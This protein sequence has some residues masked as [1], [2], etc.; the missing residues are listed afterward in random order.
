MGVQGLRNKGSEDEG[1]DGLERGQHTHS[2]FTTPIQERRS[3]DPKIPTTCHMQI[4]HVDVHVVGALSWL[5][6]P[7]SRRLC[8]FRALSILAMLDQH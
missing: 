5:F 1:L 4:M 8:M 6:G 2:N 7:A 3:I